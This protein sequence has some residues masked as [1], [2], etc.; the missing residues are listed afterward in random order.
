MLACSNQN[1]QKWINKVYLI[2]SNRSQETTLINGC[3]RLG[4]P[5][6]RYCWSDHFIIQKWQTTASHQPTLL[7]KILQRDLLFCFDRRWLLVLSNFKI[8]FIRNCHFRTYCFLKLFIQYIDYV[9]CSLFSWVVD[10]TP[11]SLS[12]K[13]SSWEPR[14][15]CIIV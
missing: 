6:P 7:L 1:F 5:S 2:L 12:Y 8:V 10:N 9:R 4:L 15:L 13:T 14:T 11:L 3:L